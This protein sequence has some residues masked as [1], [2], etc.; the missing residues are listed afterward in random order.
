MNNN[1]VGFP[2]NCGSFVGTGIPVYNFKKPSIGN[3]YFIISAQSFTR[4][5]S[6]ASSGTT[7][8]KDIQLLQSSGASTITDYN[9]SVQQLVPN[10]YSTTITSSNTG[11]ILAPSS[12]GIASGVSAGASTLRAFASGDSSLF[13]SINVSVSSSSGVVNSSFL[14]YA[15]GSLAKSASDAIDTRIAGKNP[16]TTKSVYSTQ[17]HSSGIYVRNTNCWVSGVDLTSI[18]PWNSTGSN[19]MAGTLISPRHILFAAHYQI[20]NHATIRFIDNNNNVITRTMTSKLTH[21]S[22]SPY[23]PDISI[24]V[25]DSDVPASI[26]FARILPSNWASYLP[27]LSNLYRIPCLVLDQEEKALISDLYSLN[28]SAGCLVP[29]DATR[30]S[31]FE[32]FIIGD[33]GNP[34]FL[35]INGQ[36][37]LITVLTFGGAGSGT[38]IVY[39]KDAINTMMAT[40][41]GGYS[42]TEISLN[43][44]T[45][46]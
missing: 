1:A 14:S 31:F 39:H 35:I 16:S 24:G 15:S 20:E 45:L 3:D 8:I 29:T 27:S 46:F 34:V 33:S 17:N 9:V 42:L 41:G 38:S 23:Y 25:L 12:A 43:N 10:T 44:F 22:Y 7:T 21:P 4:T 5:I 37:V 26:S 30:L 6:A 19:T 28:T 40:L 2:L 32:N 11:V 36:L 18:S 13:S